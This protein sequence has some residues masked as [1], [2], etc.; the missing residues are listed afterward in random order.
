MVNKEEILIEYLK[1]LYP[2]IKI[3]AEYS[4]DDNDVDVIVVQEQPGEKVVFFEDTEPLFNYFQINIYGTSIRQS[5]YISNQIGNLIG[6]H[7]KIKIDKN[8]WQIIFM[9]Y[10]NPQPIEYLD[11][12][13]I[14]YTSTMKCII[15]QIM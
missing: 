15:N 9:Q 8:T 13:R 2:S 6:K 11:I 12:R 4:T 3:K 1:E 14:G 7:V 5:K 10:S